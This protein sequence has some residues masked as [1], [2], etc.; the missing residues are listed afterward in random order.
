M[1]GR[2]AP[3]QIAARGLDADSLVALLAGT[4]LKPPA[5]SIDE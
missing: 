3:T 2:R 5:Q 1:S 4:P